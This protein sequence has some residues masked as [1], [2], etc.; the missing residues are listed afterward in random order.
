MFQRGQLREGEAENRGVELS[1][2]W[3]PDNWRGSTHPLVRLCWPQ[4]AQKKYSIREGTSE[5]PGGYR[6]ETD[7]EWLLLWP[8]L[9]C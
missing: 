4:K 7:A 2:D 9:G 8:H 6:W 5:P 1:E 3:H